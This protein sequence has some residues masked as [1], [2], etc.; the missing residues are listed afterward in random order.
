V[1]SALVARTSATI[2]GRASQRVAGVA[3]T[4]T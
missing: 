3:S 4:G 2:S 1:T